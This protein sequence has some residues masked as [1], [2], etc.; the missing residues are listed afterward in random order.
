MIRGKV[1]TIVRSLLLCTLL[2]LGTVAALLVFRTGTLGK[3]LTESITSGSTSPDESLSK[4]LDRMENLEQTSVRGGAIR[5]PDVPDRDGGHPLIVA[6]HGYG[7]TPEDAVQLVHSSLFTEAIVVAP[8]GTFLSA[9]EHR[10][11]D[12]GYSWDQGKQDPHATT[13]ATSITE[14]R[15]LASVREITALFDVSGVYMVGFSQGGGPAVTIALTNP[16][17]FDA[18]I[19][20]SGVP[21]AHHLS[22][23]ELAEACSTRVLVAHSPEDAVVPFNRSAGM[24]SYLGRQG[25]DVSLVEYE[26]GHVPS[27]QTLRYLLFRM[28]TGREPI[29][30]DHI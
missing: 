24:T 13:I 28:L 7:S 3:R 30:Q 27:D 22:D 29:L 19:C 26:G 18:V 5:L 16:D 8:R 4:L 6:L 1:R 10:G 11:W 21:L 2:M 23:E 17:I 20:F 12:R 15:V 14:A 9:R 25:L